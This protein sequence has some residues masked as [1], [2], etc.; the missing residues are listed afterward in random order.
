MKEEGASSF[1]LS[2]GNPIMLLL[3]VSFISIVSLILFLNKLK[4][5]HHREIINLKESHRNDLQNLRIKVKEDT[6]NFIAAEIHDHI[7]QL[8]AVVKLNLAMQKDPKLNESRALV[9]RIINDMREMVHS[10]SADKVRH[11]NLD[12]SIENEV[13]RLQQTSTYSISYS[14]KGEPFLIRSEK[15]VGIFRIFQECIT[16]IIKHSDARNI[17]VELYFQAKLFTLVIRDDGQG[18][19]NRSA[20][21]GV[22]LQ[23]MEYRAQL[24]GASLEVDTSPGTG[25]SVTLTIVP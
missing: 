25:C 9:S 24:L 6:L 4:R 18:F 5:K 12:Q 14:P 11:Q 19:D 17:A 23:N 7:G 13:K 22:G 8:L 15:Q 2:L 16:N 1:T 21:V 3:I 20:N 10:M